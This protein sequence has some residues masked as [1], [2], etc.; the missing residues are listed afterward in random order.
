VEEKF[1]LPNPFLLPRQDLEAFWQ[2]PPIAC[3]GLQTGDI[4]T[5]QGWMEFDCYKNNEFKYHA[6]VVNFSQGHDIGKDPVFPFSFSLFLIYTDLQLFTSFL[7][8]IFC[9]LFFVYL[10]F[11]EQTISFYIEKHKW[12]QRFVLGNSGDSMPS[13][14]VM[15]NFELY[16]IQDYE[17]FLSV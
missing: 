1:V 4:K 11:F 6:Y 13:T 14:I 7:F 17:N 10:F 12:M 3:I 8:Q 16:T 15:G 9:S 5:H 2:S